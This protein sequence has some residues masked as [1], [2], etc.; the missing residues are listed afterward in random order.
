[1]GVGLCRAGLGTVPAITRLSRCHSL[2]LLSAVTL[3]LIPSGRRTRCWPGL[4]RL[5]G[6]GLW[7][8]KQLLWSDR[9]CSSLQPQLL[10]LLL[11]GFFPL[12]LLPSLGHSL[13]ARLLLLLR[14]RGLVQICQWRNRIKKKSQYQRQTLTELCWASK[15]QNKENTSQ[16]V[17]G[18]KCGGNLRSLEMFC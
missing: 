13:G 3:P 15:N 18:R 7:C 6:L 4:L 14:L 8:R 9:G 1:M 11:E 10:A 17:T 16:G 12:Q 5:T 2:L